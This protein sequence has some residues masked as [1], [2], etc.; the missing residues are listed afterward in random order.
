MFFCVA[1]IVAGADTAL[2]YLFKGG[3]VLHQRLMPYQ[4]CVCVC[5]CVL[6]ALPPARGREIWLGRVG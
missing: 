1:T 5:A 2:L 3:G 6:T 4:V